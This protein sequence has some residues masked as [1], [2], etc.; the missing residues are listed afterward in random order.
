MADTLKNHYGVNFNE[1]FNRLVTN[2]WDR[3]Q[4]RV[5][6]KSIDHIDIK[7]KDQF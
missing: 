5:G 6:C 1:R 3:A 2:S 7:L 4:E